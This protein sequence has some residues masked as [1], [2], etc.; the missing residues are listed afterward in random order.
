MYRYIQV[1]IQDTIRPGNRV[2]GALFVNSA[3][4]PTIGNH[5]KVQ[6]GRGAGI[7]PRRLSLPC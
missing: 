1:S 5:P 2:V 7:L 3:L 4:H 6:A